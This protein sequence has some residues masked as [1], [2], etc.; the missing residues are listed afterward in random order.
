MRILILLLV[1]FSSCSPKKVASK[2][3]V[4]GD[5]DGYIARLDSH[6]LFTDNTSDTIAMK[7]QLEVLAAKSIN[8]H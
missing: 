4:Y 1:I 2:V 5:N 8:K 6:Y 3:E 7:K